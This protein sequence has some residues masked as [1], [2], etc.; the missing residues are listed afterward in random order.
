[1]KRVVLFGGIALLATVFAVVAAGWFSW[2]S[3]LK[4]LKAP[5]SVTEETGLRLPSDARITAT[6]AD[7]FSLAD[8]ENYDWLIRSDTSLLPWATT[9]MSVERGGWEH[10]HQLAEL[11]EF[12]DE[13]PP[14]T[15]FGGVWKGVRRSSRGRE[16][17]SYLYLAED[18]RIGILS[19]FRP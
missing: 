3:D 19:T 8:G 4:R 16:E 5:E 10:I 9:N 6:R 11:R 12:K 17:T 18:G 7:I 2:R 13:I 15:K 1:M 14:T